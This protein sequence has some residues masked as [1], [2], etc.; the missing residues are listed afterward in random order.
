MNPE[1][2]IDIKTSLAKLYTLVLFIADFRTSEPSYKL[3]SALLQNAQFDS[4]RCTNH[5]HDAS[6]K[7][8]YDIKRILK[9]FSLYEKND[10]FYEFVYLEYQYIMDRYIMKEFSSEQI[11]P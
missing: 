8:L 11:N 6:V 5:N 9:E 2:L 3:I 1:T 7:E 4:S 10:P